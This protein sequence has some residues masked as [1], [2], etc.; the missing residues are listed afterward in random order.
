MNVE[1]GISFYKVEEWDNT[2]LQDL[3]DHP[4]YNIYIQG[5]RKAYLEVISEVVLALFGL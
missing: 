1:L 2:N 4:K 3:I 5:V